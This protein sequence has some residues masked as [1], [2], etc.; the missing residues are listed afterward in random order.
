MTTDRLCSQAPIHFEAQPQTGFHPIRGLVASTAARSNGIWR[1]F[2]CGWW[3]PLMG[4]VQQT[5]RYQPWWRKRG[6][7]SKVLGARVNRKTYSMNN[8]VT[9]H[10]MMST[11][12]QGKY[13]MCL[14]RSEPWL[15]K[16]KSAIGFREL[17]PRSMSYTTRDF[18]GYFM[19]WSPVEIVQAWLLSDWRLG[20]TLTSNSGHANSNWSDFKTE[21]P[22][23][24][25]PSDREVTQPL[26]HHVTKLCIR[27]I[28]KSTRTFLWIKRMWSDYS[29]SVGGQFI[30]ICLKIVKKYWLYQDI[31]SCVK[32][33]F[34]ACFWLSDSRCVSHA[35]TSTKLEQTGE[36]FLD[37]RCCLSA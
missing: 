26:I 2:E 8:T 11:M 36:I 13:T 37:S 24:L 15:S 1:K 17:T 34:F 9:N 22:G 19:A 28:S 7:G 33:N 27:P 5:G 23:G 21:S 20:Q 32:I 12:T 4:T 14:V 31:F 25:G 18:I 29:K 6:T 30:R 16:L 10:G 35:I 3:S